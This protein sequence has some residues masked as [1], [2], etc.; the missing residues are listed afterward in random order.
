MK[1]KTIVMIAAG[2]VAYRLIFKAWPGENFARMQ[3]WI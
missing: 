3:G 2:L 1:T